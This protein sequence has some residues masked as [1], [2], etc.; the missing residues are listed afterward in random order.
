MSHQLTT[1]TSGM[2]CV[3]SGEER[4]NDTAGFIRRHHVNTAALTP[5]FLSTVEPSDVPT[6]DTLVV[7]GERPSEELVAKWASRVKLI[8]VY[9]STETNLVL[10]TIQ[11]AGSSDVVFKP[12]G[13]NV[14]ITVPGDANRLVNVGTPGELAIE[15]WTLA[16]GYL[17]D[18]ADKTAAKFVQT[19]QWLQDIR[20]GAETRLFLTGDMAVMQA[21][22]HVRILGR[23]DDVT[24]IRGQKID[25]G[26]VEAAMRRSLPPR[27]HSAVCPSED[28]EHMLSFV[29]L[30]EEMPDPN[31][32]LPE[33]QLV[34]SPAVDEIVATIE[35][36]LKAKLPTYLVPS[37]T[38][39][40]NRFPLTAS[41]K[42]DRQAL[43][44][45]RRDACI[46]T[47]GNKRK[48]RSAEE[49]AMC[50][51][52]STVLKL[53][54]SDIGLDDDFFQL[55]GH[56]LAAIRLVSAAR[57][58]GISLQVKLI[59][60]HSTLEDL[61]AKTIH[62][63]ATTPPAIEPLKLISTAGSTPMAELLE[64]IS[65]Q[66][67]IQKETVEDMYPCSPLQSGIMALTMKEPGAY[68]ARCI[69]PLDVAVDESRLTEAWCAAYQKCPIL[70]TR[71]V[72]T[73]LG[74]LQVVLREDLEWNTVETDL[75]T[76]LEQDRMQHMIL[77]SRLSRL[78][79]VH[80]KAKGRQLIWTVHHAIMDAWAIKALLSL[81]S[82][83]YSETQHQPLHN[84]NEYIQ[85]LELVDHQ[86]RN[87]YW[88]SYLENCALPG[89]PVLTTAV[90]EYTPQ[91]DVVTHKT[92]CLPLKPSSPVTPATVIRAGW[93]LL[94]AQYSNSED[95][96]FGAT[97]SGRTIDLPQIDC[98]LG[99]TICTVP[100]RTRL[101]DKMSVS[102]FLNRV[103]REAA[104]MTPY[105]HIGLQNL[106]R[107]SP[108][109]RVACNFQTHLII[110]SG[111]AEYPPSL[112]GSVAR[113]DDWRASASYAI[114]LEC[115]VRGADL[116]CE[117]VFDPRAVSA[118]QMDLM[119]THFGRLLDQLCT[120]GDEALLRDL[121]IITPMETDM[122]LQNRRLP[123]TVDACTHDMIRE[124]GQKH[125]EHEAVCSWDGN[126]TY[127]ELEEWSN[128]VAKQL[129]LA[130]TTSPGDVIPIMTEKSLWAIVAMIAIW[131]AGCAWTLL[132]TSHPDAW[133]KQIIEDGNAKVVVCTEACLQRLPQEV[134][135]FVVDR[136]MVDECPEPSEVTS[137]RRSSPR[138]V[139]FILYTSGSTG[140]PKAIPHEHVAFLSG[141]AARLPIIK[142]DQASRVL[143]F[144]S[145]AFDTAIED[146]I[147]TFLVGGTVCIPS[148]N[149]RQNDLV[150]YMN[151]MRVSHADFTPS[152]ASI[153][154]TDRPPSLK[155]LTLSGETVT[156]AHRDAWAHR[157]TLINSYGPSEVAIV[158]HTGV[159]T[160]SSLPS[161][162]GV[163]T[164]CLDWIVRLDGSDRLQA[165]GCVGEL[166]LEGPILSRGY[167][168]NDA[169]TRESFITNPSWLPVD[170]FGPR[171]LYRTGD[172]A[173][174]TTDG[175]V[176][177]VGRKDARMRKLRGQRIEVSQVEAYV[178][179]SLA[180][181]KDRG[182][183]GIID[184]L[185]DVVNLTPAAGGGRPTQS[186]V[187]FV[188]FGD[189][190][191]EATDQEIAMWCAAIDQH[192]RNGL[193]PYMVPTA[194]VPLQRFP[195]TV[196][197]KADKRELV[198]LVEDP[199]LQ[200]RICYLSMAS[201]P[202]Q[203][204]SAKGP[205][206]VS[207]PA[208]RRLRD[209]WAETLAISPDGL[210]SDSNFVHLG[211]DSIL[212]MKM[213]A[214][215]NRKG[216]LGFYTVELI[217]RNPFLSDMARRAT[218]MAV[219]RTRAKVDAEPVPSFQLFDVPVG[220][221]AGA[222]ER[223]ASL[224]ENCGPDAVEDVYP[225][226]RLQQGLMA[227]SIK[228]PGTYTS[229]Q[230]FELPEWIDIA[231]FKHA[232]NTVHM[233]TPIL[234][235][236]IVQSGADAALQVVVREVSI[237]WAEGDD[238]ED[239]L[240]KD[241][242]RLMVQG[243]RLSRYA[244]LK[245]GP[246]HRFVW[247]MH[248]AIYD[249]WCVSLILDSVIRAYN[250]TFVKPRA[251][252]N[253]FVRHLIQ[254]A[255]PESN[256]HFWRDYLDGVTEAAI[257]PGLPSPTHM[258]C[259]DASLDYTMSLSAHDLGK[260]NVTLTTVLYTAWGMLASKY[261]DSADVVFGTTRTG[262]GAPVAGIDEIAGPTFATVPF[263]MS[264]QD[265]ISVPELLGRV[266]AQF[267]ELL[268]YEHFGLHDIKAVSD[269][270]ATASNFQTLVVVQPKDISGGQ[271]DLATLTGDMF[272][273]AHVSGDISDFNPYSIMLQL[274]PSSSN[275]VV[276]VNVSFDS[277][278]VNVTQ[279]QRILYQME[280]LVHE[281][282]HHVHDQAATLEDVNYLSRQDHAEILAWNNDGIAPEA[283]NARVHDVITQ[284]AEK[285]PDEPA[286][287]LWDGKN[288][289][290]MTYRE[291][292]DL[293]S[294]LSWDLV[295][296]GVGPETIVP[297]CCEKSS[298]AV[299]ALLAVLKAGGAFVL[300]DPA[301]PLDRLLSVVR[302]TA[303]KI[304]I[305]SDKC[306]QLFI[307][308][309]EASGL[310]LD[311]LLERNLM[312]LASSSGSND[313]ETFSDDIVVQAS[314]S[315]LACVVFTS[316]STGRPKGIQLQ[317]SAICT[318]VLRG[319]G[320][321][322]NL[323]RASRVFQF[324]SFAFD[325]ALYDICGTLMMG[326]C[327]CIP[328][329]T[330]RLNGLAAS[331]RAMQ[332]NWAFF[333]PSTVTLLSPDEV[334]CLQNLTVGG[335][336]VKQETVD[337]WA[338]RVNLFQCSGPAE[339]TTCV[340]QPMKPT[341]S[342][343]RLGKG[344]GV[345][346]WVVSQQSHDVLAPIGTVGELV[347][348]GATVAR[349]YLADEHNALGL[350][351][352]TPKWAG[353]ANGDADTDICP[354][355]AG[356][357]RK[358]YRCGDLVR[359]ESD[360]GLSFIGR[361]D[362]QIKV[363]GQRI[364]L[365]EV[366]ECMK[367]NTN[368]DVVAEVIIPASERDHQGKRSALLVLLIAIG[369]ED[370]GLGKH[371]PLCSV[372]SQPP[373]HFYSEV[374]HLH[375][376][377]TA[378]LP[379][380]M[381]PSFYVPVS[382]VPLNSSG[383]V[384]RKMLKG[385]C[386]QLSIK[387]LGVFSSPEEL[388]IPVETPMERLMQ[389]LWAQ[390]LK[391]EVNTIGGNSNLLHMGGDSISAMQLVALATSRGLCITVADIFRTPELG[392]LCRSVTSILGDSGPRKV[393]HQPFGLLRSRG[394]EGGINDDE[395]RRSLSRSLEVNFD[396]IEDAYPCTPLQEGLMLS[397]VQSNGG[398]YIAQEVYA[399]PSEVNLKRFKLA[400]EIV[401]QSH[402]VLRS[403]ITQLESLGCIN[404]VLRGRLQQ[405]YGTNVDEYL[406]RDRENPIGFGDILTRWAIIVS[407]PRGAV[408]FVWTRHHSAYDGY[409]LQVALEDIGA[410]YNSEITLSAALEPHNSFRDL[411]HYLNERDNSES[412]AYWERSLGSTSATAVWRS[413]SHVLS[414]S[415]VEKA[416]LDIALT[417]LAGSSVTMATC[418]R[419]AWAL[420]LQK[421][422][423]SDSVIFGET[424]SGRNIPLTGVDRC[425]G[426][427]FTT[428]PVCIVVD[429]GLA[430][431]A[432]LQVVQDQFIEMIPHQHYGLQNIMQINNNLR[433]ACHYDSLLIIQP[434]AVAHDDNSFL[435]PVKD[436]GQS[437]FFTNSLTL[438]FQTTAKGIRVSLNYDKSVLSSKQAQ[439]LLAQ[440][441][442][443][444]Q[445]LASGT[446]SLDQTLTLSEI[447]YMSPSDLID[448]KQWNQSPPAPTVIE[449]CIH[450]VIARVAIKSPDA[451][452][453][454]AW[455]GTF[456]YAE[457]DLTASRLAE[458][459]KVRGVSTGTLVPLIF[460]KSCWFIVSVVAV[461][462]S[463]GAFV[464]ISH[465]D[466]Q[467]RI[468]S[469][470]SSCAAALVLTS[471]E[472][473]DLAGST[474]ATTL[475]VTKDLVGS[476]VA[477]KERTESE[478]HT[479]RSIATVPSDLSCV[480]FTSGSTGIPKGIM[481][482]HYLVCTNAAVHAP[483]ISISSS[484]RSLHFSNH[485]WDALF[486]EV[487]YPLMQGGC[488]CVPPDQARMNGLA[489]VLNATRANWMF[490]TPTTASLLNPS[491]V[492]GLE[493]L[494]MGGEAASAHV[495]RTWQVFGG[496]LHNI[497]GPAECGVFC[498]T[499]RK[500][501]LA[502]KPSELGKRITGRLWL[503]DPSNHNK[504][505]PIG[506]VGELLVESPV[507]A[508]GYLHQPERTAESFLKTTNWLNRV[509]Q[510]PEY[511]L[512]SRLYKTGDL[513]RYG[514]DGTLEF[515]GRRDFQFK[516]N[517][518]RVDAADIEQ[519][520]I[521]HLGTAWDLV[522]VDRVSIP[523]A[524]TKAVVAAFIDVSGG[525]EAARGDKDGRRNVYM[526][527]ELR[528]RFTR[529]QEALSETL[530]R[531]M[532]PT[533]Y[534]PMDGM[535]LTAT[536][537]L[538]RRALRALCAGL[539]SSQLDSYRLLRQAKERPV[540]AAEIQLQRLWSQVLDTPAESIGR[541]DRF[542][543]L[544]GDSIAAM[545]LVTLARREG[546]SI[547]VATVFRKPRLVDMAMTLCSSKK[548]NSGVARVA[549]Y[550]PFSLITGD[551]VST[552]TRLASLITYP[553][554]N[555][556]DIYPATSFQA[557]S[558]ASGLLQSRGMW[559]YF[560]FEGSGELDLDR[561]KES[562]SRLVLAHPI[563]R[564]VFVR[565]G[566]EIQQVVLNQINSRFEVSQTGQP[567][568]AAQTLRVVS[569]DM[570]KPIQLGDTFV[571]FFLIRSR[572]SNLFRLIVRMNHAQYDSFSLRG[573]WKTLTDAYQEAVD[574]VPS[575]DPKS[576][577]AS[578]VAAYSLYMQ[579][580][581]AQRADPRSRNYWRNLLRGVALTPLTTRLSP[582]W[583]HSQ[584]SSI[585]SEVT[586]AR[587][588]NM[589]T[590]GLG[591]GV[592]PATVVKAAWA[593]VLRE[594]MLPSTADNHD[595]VVFL[596]TISGR[597]TTTADS[598][599]GD[600]VGA[601]LNVVPVRV[602]LDHDSACTGAGL[603]RRIQDQN[604]AGLEF[605]LPGLDGMF[606]KDSA[607]QD[608][609]GGRRGLGWAY[610][611]G[612]LVQHDG[613]ISGSMA[614]HE[615]DENGE[616]RLGD[617]VL[618][619]TESLG[620]PG[621]FADIAIHSSSAPSV[622][623]NSTNTV[624]EDVTG[625]SEIYRLSVQVTALAPEIQGDLVAHM[626]DR[627]CFHA[628]QLTAH[629]DEPVGRRVGMGDARW[630]IPLPEE[631][632][633]T[634]PSATLPPPRQ[635]RTSTS[636]GSPVLPLT[637]TEP[638]EHLAKMLE[639][640]WSE[641][642]GPAPPGAAA[643]VDL[644]LSFF[645]QG[646]DIVRV[647][648]LADA[649]RTEGYD[650]SMEAL[651]SRRYFYEQLSLLSAM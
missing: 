162:V 505:A 308:V 629:P 143:Q 650:V 198:R 200:T 111:E 457:L 108:E 243:T 442:H 23:L 234:R 209:L 137:W 145:Y 239:F 314:P 203:E 62:M 472:T 279:M 383:K 640:M 374:S 360:G 320:P 18:S 281:L 459:L 79:V 32:P 102:S 497:Y 27:C 561:L 322:L 649:L 547:D 232:W 591:H 187:V 555:I 22:G 338:G 464:G 548:S 481:L 452:A 268:T 121:E 332:A 584:P 363:R 605:G 533:L 375:A 94:L 574:A 586:A 508:R 257:F 368:N 551:R 128:A 34:W 144:S 110:Q 638:I 496:N 28:G 307:S 46:S 470:L 251:D 64:E 78:S 424:L 623:D 254:N 386:S 432:F 554:S 48:P 220:G 478:T 306:A 273:N 125:P 420:I 358:F 318:S 359:Y 113:I 86:A 326:G 310:D 451:V 380:Y 467:D 146:S 454:E 42:L 262:R 39:V 178:A 425:P 540:G 9:G 61:S 230:V 280:H 510:A 316:G 181:I 406:Q 36:D 293:S 539:E 132:D 68:S 648:C 351:I 118:E 365:A 453:I 168:N 169:K 466:P 633:P 394:A 553:T 116:G 469:I 127:G 204:A 616:I 517:G 612:S 343:S 443:V 11:P 14:W 8:L 526:D 480:V 167:L 20:L 212:A 153:M 416:D 604:T 428:V 71:I 40:I 350:F 636:G 390:V 370:P 283:E 543:N 172:L 226:T 558:V 96:V 228:R 437:S 396:N 431:S 565:N 563:L 195:L 622:T 225:C 337:V 536:G 606:D 88:C 506:C 124:Q 4:L 583:R 468:Y 15:S 219:A 65:S 626:A 413:T 152:F 240:L 253:Q 542:L 173:R 389:E 41:G 587:H 426:P 160:P 58:M 208:E 628:E 346:C 75:E 356:P 157:V 405:R 303:A 582:A 618:R 184:V 421:Y 445:Q 488:V 70:R 334:P 30:N 288:R 309:E 105:E 395:V 566:G 186:L 519:H 335:E 507:L 634:A 104:E 233:S 3:P 429:H 534:V 423:G 197:G 266:Q 114:N 123:D 191:R 54:E 581:A 286:I 272:N 237:D 89:F 643:V 412:I 202:V 176:E 573:L 408:Y 274:K 199:A 12:V 637:P 53:P 525:D 35:K 95:V 131:K 60:E 377:A 376:R 434:E 80:D 196:H 33:A 410:A 292:D 161:N 400:C 463:G 361:K 287:C 330:S 516:V 527:N 19:P 651:F 185:A 473:V 130:G 305:T 192:L 632:G 24:K 427:T 180:G 265:S 610:H 498:I 295:R 493:T 630:R 541:H 531:F 133:M 635:R 455:D 5:S 37:Q 13:C 398:A 528:Q 163:S 562:C 564:T 83:L 567:D 482:E 215:A 21:D 55:G 1:C 523:G 63:C 594:L 631:R 259:A 627:I 349:G 216:E 112:L 141:V 620:N 282:C 245:D 646:G 489:E 568:L 392:K 66:Y 236:R 270:A 415:M 252:Y 613:D 2:V 580:Y 298:F 312:D 248:H 214:L 595:D 329:E 571:A 90:S 495:L 302:Q 56:S 126:L 621:D 101:D 458:H 156:L 619:P 601:Y 484:T 333:T 345:L 182:E 545:R 537:K 119:L 379:P 158:S 560:T 515:V 6:L 74:T 16:R 569:L 149:D 579:E 177:I 97:L 512:S 73:N 430:A 99:P 267:T 362:T 217:L 491:D 210:G 10:Q 98:I 258:V 371:S 409:S 419:A 264:L 559:G 92:L 522:V 476:L 397:S 532:I 639:D 26:E 311:I 597:A 285:Y 263:R 474:G 155:V 207:T 617:A 514:D 47:E 435:R 433:E 342:R 417:T 7:G 100:V 385:L 402:H 43:L 45:L 122:F 77:G 324:A 644:G 596:T 544:G 315:S 500:H 242:K 399:L 438:I 244:L 138:S 325:M 364:E 136:K 211:G 222:V 120:H 301:H 76:F 372:I 67:A 134:K 93:A 461:L 503:C 106:R 485:C 529:L 449:D 277:G 129:V 538:D 91:P 188:S 313:T 511:Q 348:E 25:L 340:T 499:N 221:L 51:L 492:P 291:L 159:I 249:G 179:E 166:L 271:A 530:P 585:G 250:G 59:F 572:S 592:T 213:V 290:E 331:I 241:K 462:K 550:K 183:G 483:A 151:R 556:A 444:L 599:D 256:S 296:K 450:D 84:F 518:Q 441:A 49:L 577:M 246:T 446:C 341:T 645:D 339:T 411:I 624:D 576:S 477:G 193:P 327:V 175:G 588:G 381:V 642:L 369:Q 317:H 355:E 321:A 319:H 614:G 269:N 546:L 29:A 641:V 117:V 615:A 205:V 85:H 223:L 607:T 82:N 387:D 294:Q 300:L 378:C 140:K 224:C 38:L 109:L 373:D 439:R 549:Q 593:L 297:I 382:C 501:K 154:S 299:V 218:E 552:K 600:A 284:Q 229:Q 486:I 353:N 275:A 504:L 235:T 357:T 570:S 487:V 148:E 354:A 190:H 261:L 589:Y 440:F 436:G 447:D 150:G 344:A 404:V 471:M 328:T 170:Q 189:A 260:A 448:L 393:Q 384:D 509:S 174:Y 52:W 115:T 323:T 414:P 513:L 171:R 475:V 87:E 557:L 407:E 238:V 231:R 347:I 44:R 17:G 336:A 142:R 352:P 366:E 107:L 391:V 456:T 276:D 194:M 367:Q 578:G 575:Y 524:L 72:E 57:R 603:M 520:I 247:T 165:R 103:Q 521:A 289:S 135:R 598:R 590:A 535:P 81:V 304:L 206:S 50:R 611:G 465:E 502:V 388:L 147:V 609:C 31:H 278:V 647:C 403:C 625:F 164:G 494:V 479:S 227:L 418:I 255:D 602:H 490:A 139:A 608:G 422:S 69:I 401:Y 201:D 460:P